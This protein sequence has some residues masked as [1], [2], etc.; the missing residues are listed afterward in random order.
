MTSYVQRRALLAQVLTFQM[1][2]MA[3]QRCWPKLDEYVAAQVA[4]QPYAMLFPDVALHLDACLVCVNAYNLVYELALAEAHETLPQFAQI[5]EPDLFFLLSRSPVRWLEQLRAG[6]QRVGEQISLQLTPALAATLRPA[7]A[8]STQRGAEQRYAE[9]LLQLEP[10]LAL[11]DEW[12]VK[13]MAYR[14]TLQPALCLVEVTV[15]PPDRTWPELEGIKVTLTGDGES[16]I[17][18]TDAWGLASFP[19]VPVKWLPELNVSVAL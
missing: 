10:T 7:Y 14:D 1:N 13:L 16:H 17:V 8:A 6:L 4:G 9:P 2:E 5:P 18:A 15:E 19:G 12:P 11:Q 3:C